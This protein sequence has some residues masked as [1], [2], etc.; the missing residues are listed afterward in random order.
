M[1]GV[2]LQTTFLKEYVEKFGYLEKD[3]KIN[4]IGLSEL[5]EKY[6]FESGEIRF[7]TIESIKEILKKAGLEYDEFIVAY[8]A[9]LKTL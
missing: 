1:P 3:V 2:Y 8:A 9:Y 4:T 7:L 5:G 6:M